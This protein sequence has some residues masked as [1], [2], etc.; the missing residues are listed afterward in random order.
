MNVST[1]LKSTKLTGFLNGWLRTHLADV[2]IGCLLACCAGGFSYWGAQQIDLV[3]FDPKTIDAWFESDLPRVFENITDRSSNHYRTKVHPLFSLLAFPP[4]FILRQFFNLDA[5]TAARVMIAAIAGIWAS[6]LFSLLRLMRCHR[7]DASLLTGLGLVSAASMFWFVVPE[8]Y[9]FGSLSILI[10]LVFTALSEAYTLPAIAFVGVSALTMSI[11]ITN[12]M[13]GLLLTAVNHPWKRALQ[14]SMNAF[15]L[16]TLLWG[17]QKF[18]FTS[19]VFFLGDREESQYMM[20]SGGI[21]TVL[22]SFVVHTLVMP[23]IQMV[24][25]VNGRP[26]WP[27]MITQTSLPGSGSLLG[28][29]AVGLWLGLLALSLWA[30][31]T[32]KTHV[33]LRLVLAFSLL[34]QFA[35]HSIYGNETFLYSL[36]FL[37]LFIALVAFT[38]LT[39]VRRLSLS[40]ILALIVTVGINN[41]QQF[42]QAKAFFLTHGSPRHLVQSQMQ[43]R[44][45]DP[46]PRGTGHVVLATPGS[47]EEEKSYHE[48]GGSFSPAVNS[49]GVSL[50]LTDDHGYLQATS[51]TIPLDAIDQQLIHQTDAIAPSILTKTEDYQMRWSMISDHRW[52]MTLDLPERDRAQPMVVIRSVGPAG[53]AIQ[54]LDWHDQRLQI[55]DRWS[56][57]VEP[58]TPQ[59]YLGSETTQGW[60]TE[61]EPRSSWQGDDGW[62]YAK[63]KLGNGQTWTLTL[64][65]L[66]PPQSTNPLT[67]QS[68][69]TRFNLSLPDARFEES[70]QAQ[71]THLLMGLVGQQTRPGEPTNY[72]I[73]WLRDGAYTLVALSRTG[74]ADVAQQLSTYFA[75]NDFF[76]GFGPEA[77]A[78]G[79]AIWALENV[80][81]QIQDPTFDEWLWP[82]IRRKAE[83]IIKMMEADQP[84]HLQPTTPIVPSVIENQKQ[85]SEITLV[86]EPA[87]Q[88]LIIGRMDHHRPLLYVNAIS[89]GGLVQAANL[90]ERLNQTEAA[91]RWQMKAQALRQAW[92]ATFEPPE[93]LNDRTYMSGLWPTWVAADWVTPFTE[94]LDRRWQEQRTPEGNYLKTP[95]WPYFDLAETHQWLF[96]KYPE[97]VWQTLNW[98]WDNQASPG[99]YTWWEGDGEENS[100]RRWEKVRGWVDPPH[101]TPHYWTAAEMSLLQL[102]MLAY[103]DKTSATPHLVIGGGIPAQWLE[104][105][106]QVTGLSLDGYQVN[107]NWDGEQMAVQILGEPIDVILGPSFSEQSS[108]NVDFT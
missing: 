31:F 56:I 79:L 20:I 94:G 34:G 26:D 49:F 100:Y 21:F 51:D 57:R 6:S 54:T 82:H 78:P 95:L 52:Q 67:I 39:N 17:V 74:H 36:H 22:R 68:P 97:R 62:G 101:V 107:W 2:I 81:T 50:W 14:I 13:V 86:A 12:W 77:D 71:I 106:M 38:T 53:G 44:P 40:L 61:Q 63:L 108:L 1:T 9:S 58:S 18:L 90:A 24:D 73:P 92:Q 75:E 19:A 8:T 16:V 23:A 69:T 96:L 88:G 11:T 83:W 29:L 66:Q 47:R 46:W 89:Y 104:Q 33:K 70:L 27:V 4:S 80:A 48:P 85:F 41:V 102:D 103:I 93:S 10:A 35:L 42:N 99:L 45:T 59:V 32:I 91:Q 37:P 28:S 55:N 87:Q 98:F 105:P 65:D 60:L 43:L 7:L 3:A 5:I 64:E 15:C 76:G 25:H 84:I 30:G 72:P